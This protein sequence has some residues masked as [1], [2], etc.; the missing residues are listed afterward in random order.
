MFTIGNCYYANTLSN[1]SLD[2]PLT[3]SK[4]TAK[5]VTFIDQWGESLRF[6]LRSSEHERLGRLAKHGPS[7]LAV[8]SNY[9]PD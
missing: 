3:C 1:S 9:R 2:K 5:T 4:V 6:T 7:G 8:F